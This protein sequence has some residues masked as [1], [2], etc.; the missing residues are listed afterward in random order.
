MIFTIDPTKDRASE[1]S[2]KT[3]FNLS[4]SEALAAILLLVV[5]Q[6]SSTIVNGYFQHQA[7]PQEDSQKL[8]SPLLQT[9]ESLLSS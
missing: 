5:V 2:A 3:S 8:R 4:S 7:S 6:P 1:S 9:L